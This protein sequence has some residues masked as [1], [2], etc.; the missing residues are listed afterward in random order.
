M[1]C[2]GIP[3]AGKTILASIV[4]DQLITKF[5]GDEHTGI[6]YVYFDYRQREEH[7]ETLLRNLLKQLAQKRPSLPGCVSTLYKQGI[8]GIP[9][10]L[11]ALSQAL[12]TVAKDFSKIFIIIDALDECTIYNDCRMR[13][14]AEIFSLR[15]KSAANIFATSR[16]DTEIADRFRGG[17]FIEIHARE[18]DIR[19]YLKGNLHLL[20]HSVQNDIEMRNEIEQAIVSSVR[21]M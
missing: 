15:N 11:E 19:Q 9:P 20:S 14:L 1:L 18:E 6:V 21:G 7:A 4:I 12:Q 5:H 13:F 10:S 17:V 3:G 2:Q 16:P 8:Q